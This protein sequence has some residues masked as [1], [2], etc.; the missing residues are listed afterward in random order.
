[1]G[2]TSLS[3]NEAFFLLLGLL[4]GVSSMGGV[5]WYFLRERNRRIF[6]LG[7]QVKLESQKNSE[8]MIE[9][10]G[11]QS[12]HDAMLESIQG[13]E[14]FTEKAMEELTNRFR[15]LSNTI[16]AE[17]SEEFKRNNKEQ[18]SNLLT[19][20]KEN[21]EGFKKKVEDVHLKETESL[22]ELK[23]Q[24]KSL[25][26]QSLQIGQ[27]ARNLTTALK[28]DTKI[29]GQWGEVVL[30]RYLQNAGLVE[31]ENYFVQESITTEE[32]KRRQS[33]VIVNLPDDTL[34]VIDSKVSLVH[35]EK[36]STSENEEERTLF[37]N[38]HIRS[39]KNH[40]KG[41]DLKKYHQ[42]FEQ[43]GSLN[44]VMMFVPI[45]PALSLA[46]EK[47]RELVSFAFHHNVI[48]VNTSTLMLSLRLINNLWTREKQNRNALEIAK[49]GGALYDKFIGFLEDFSLIG[50]RISDAQASYQQ[51]MNRLSEG[52][53][54]IV[55][56]I[57]ELREIGAKT[58]KRIP[59]N[60]LK[61][62]ED[63]GKDPDEPF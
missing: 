58:E 41:L 62:L 60:Y 61:S 25:S 22:V 57:E 24:I 9:F 20:L 15:N 13:R 21:I 48:L 5:L 30:E 40:I 1:M 35:Y 18:L 53:G 63:P 49:K 32:G 34:V 29:Q 10:Q 42:A 16:Y 46:L 28:G 51:G 4:I 3:T 37:G 47:D 38:E 31:N 43:K 45:E 55:R 11:L 17:K 8:V 54:N 19:P 56:R 6:E 36:F 59:Q 23:T 12:K 50:K 14:Q 26:D 44:F 2:E 52:K 27:D 33:D 39:I 7:E